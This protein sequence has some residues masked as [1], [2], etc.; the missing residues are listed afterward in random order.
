MA[1]IKSISLA[2]LL[3]AAAQAP[4][5]PDTLVVLCGILR[6]RANPEIRL[7]LLLRSV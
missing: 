5:P 1:N 6:N 2:I 7:D 3:A 4:P